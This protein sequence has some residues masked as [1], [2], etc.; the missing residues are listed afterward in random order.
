MSRSF[1]RELED[2]INS[3]LVTDKAK[4]KQAKASAK[5]APTKPA[6]KSGFQEERIYV[7]VDLPGRA[8]SQLF[9]AAGLPP[10]AGTRISAKVSTFK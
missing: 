5:P 3:D 10:S 6:A 2:R 7:T 8:V 9:K 4:K 1:N